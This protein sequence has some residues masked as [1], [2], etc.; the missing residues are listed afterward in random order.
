MQLVLFPQL[1]HADM[2]CDEA[3]YGTIVGK[4]LHEEMLPEI[5]FFSPVDLVQGFLGSPIYEVFFYIIRFDISL[6]LIAEELVADVQYLVADQLDVDA[7]F[8]LLV[9]HHRHFAVRMRNGH[10]FFPVFQIGFA[11][12]VIGQL[13]GLAREELIKQKTDAFCFAL[14]F[15]RIGEA[16]CIKQ[17]I[18][19][20]SRH[21]YDL[22]VLQYLQIYS[23]LWLSPLV[24]F[25]CI[26]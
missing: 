13:T 17:S 1:L 8:L 26:L 20:G 23:I 3:P 10:A 14:S 22:I 19:A 5:Y 7:C 25:Y 12:V 9:D 21:L 15:M 2:T 4:R 6:L 16:G 11:G 24:D 18:P